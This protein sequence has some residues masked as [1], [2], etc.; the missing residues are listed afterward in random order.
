MTDS[1]SVAKDNL[2]SIIVTR[3]HL[4]KIMWHFL[5]LVHSLKFQVLSP[6]MCIRPLDWISSSSTHLPEVRRREPCELLIN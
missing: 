5:S 2:S 4:A 3:M 1:T 6:K